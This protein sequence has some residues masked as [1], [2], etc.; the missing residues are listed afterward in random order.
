MLIIGYEAHNEN[1]APSPSQLNPEILLHQSIG[2]LWRV[3]NSI[4]RN[5]YQRIFYEFLMIN[6]T[7]SVSGIER[8][9]FK[10]TIF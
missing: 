7:E 9:L 6:S 1:K 3:G 2:H 10:S 8:V 4:F 5:R